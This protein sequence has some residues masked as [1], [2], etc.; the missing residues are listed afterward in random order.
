MLIPLM[1]FLWLII[2]YLLNITLKAGIIEQFLKRKWIK[3]S[4]SSSLSKF[5]PEVIKQAKARC[6]KLRKG[7]CQASGVIINSEYIITAKHFT[8]CRSISK[9][10]QVTY[11]K[12]HFLAKEI[13][14]P[15]SKNVD[16]ALL[17]VIN[18][19]FSVSSITLGDTINENDLVFGF[20]SFHFLP[21]IIPYTGV[22]MG[23]KTFKNKF[24]WWQVL[25]NK[26]I[27]SYRKLIQ[28]P[29]LIINSEK[30]I[31][32][33]MSGSAVYNRQG[34]LIGILVGRSNKQTKGH[35]VSIARF[36]NILKQ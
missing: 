3:T 21:K 11:Q 29:Y 8:K 4:T 14:L 5:P 15:L 26:I 30:P 35:L 23:M 20:N 10:I 31:L 28:A 18:H 9:N 33:G 12:Q 24:F 7:I 16:V 32:K 1:L 25:I 34:L 2:L 6:V 22:I 17:K 19:Q 36:Q 13:L 27:K